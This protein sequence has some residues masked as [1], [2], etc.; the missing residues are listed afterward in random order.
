MENLRHVAGY[1]G[2]LDTLACTA[3]NSSWEVVGSSWKLNTKE[4]DRSAEQ[5]M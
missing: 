3:H 2:S 4:R 5:S 1:V